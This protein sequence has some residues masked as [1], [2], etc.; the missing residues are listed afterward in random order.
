MFAITIVFLAVFPIIRFYAWDPRAGSNPSVEIPERFGIESWSCQVGYCPDIY[1]LVLDGYGRGDALQAAYDIQNEPFLSAL[2]AD[3]FLVARR[4]SSNYSTTQGSLQSALN[5][6]YWHAPQNGTTSFSIDVNVVVR[7]LWPSRPWWRWPGTG[8]R[9]H[10]CAFWHSH[11]EQQPPRRCHRRRW[12]NAIRAHRPCVGKICAGSRCSIQST[13]GWPTLDGML[14]GGVVQSLDGALQWQRHIRNSFQ[15]LGDIPSRDGP[16]FVFAHIVS[17][18][19]PYVFD[20]NGDLPLDSRMTDLSDVEGKNIWDSPRFA[21]QLNHLNQLV[22]ELVKRIQAAATNPPIIL[23]H[24]DHG[25]YRFGSEPDSRENPTDQLLAER[26][27]II[28]AVLSPPEIA[29]QF[30]DG[31][32]LVN[33]FRALFRGLFGAPL[34]LL[35]DR[36]YWNYVDPPQDVTDVVQS[37]VFGAE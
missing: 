24:G 9:L 15:A 31:M 33:V 14:S 1:Y 18:H 23:I 34:P 16:K 7:V 8:L 11:H 29:E 36:N 10:T 37:A 22:L 3:G 35:D 17:P 19:P 12:H 20:S 2:R 21:G 5:M 27:S 28:L 30:Y 4:S 6:D 26:M 32:T 25:T 13:A